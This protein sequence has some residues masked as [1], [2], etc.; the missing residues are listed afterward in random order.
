[1]AAGNTYTPIA[2]YTVSGTSTT[3]ITF[4]SLGSYTDLILT[5]TFSGNY[6]SADRSQLSLRLNGSSSSVYSDIYGIASTTGTTP[7]YSNNNSLDRLSIATLPLSN[8]SSIQKNY[9]EI[10]IGN[11][12][13]TLWT[14]VFAESS[15]VNQANNTPSI[16]LHSG[17]YCAAEAITSITIFEYSNLYYFYAGSTFNLYGITKA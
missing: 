15:N 10:Q 13:S 12:A 6:T 2:S 11:Y 4:S 14:P 5:G 9:V 1:M 3:S 8:S 17:M 16:Q 7:T